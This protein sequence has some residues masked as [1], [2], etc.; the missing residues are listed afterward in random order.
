[1]SS[2]ALGVGQLPS[3][4]GQRIPPRRPDDDAPWEERLRWLADTLPPRPRHSLRVDYFVKASMDCMADG[5]PR[6]P[7][8]YYSVLRKLSRP[9]RHQGAETFAKRVVWPSLA[10]SL[11]AGDADAV[12]VLF[13][14]AVTSGSG[15][16][17]QVANRLTEAGCILEPKVL[18]SAVL[19]SVRTRD[20]DAFIAL[21]PLAL[22]SGLLSKQRVLIGT[23]LR[24]AMGFPENGTALAE[25]KRMMS[26]D[27][28]ACFLADS[29]AGA[30]AGLIWS[31][32]S[33]STRLYA[34]A[35]FSLLLNKP[36]SEIRGLA[37]HGLIWFDDPLGNPPIPVTIQPMAEEVLAGLQ[38]QMAVQWMKT[39]SL[40]Q[41]TDIESLGQSRWQ[42]NALMPN[43]L[44]EYLDLTICDAPGECAPTVV[45]D[46]WLDLAA[47]APIQKRSEMFAESSEFLGPP[48]HEALRRRYGM[49]WPVS[50][51][52]EALTEI[53]Y[54]YL[55]C[56]CA[57]K[58]LELWPL[59]RLPK[60]LRGLAL[61]R[62]R[63][64][65]E[66]REQLS[67][68]VDDGVLSHKDAF[69]MHLHRLSDAFDSEQE[70][71]TRPS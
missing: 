60:A 10:F 44:A 36:L 14:A 13:T 7:P 30:V 62:R 68:V 5:Q 49:L 21:E 12:R 33:A 71:G 40:R 46:C 67:A 28:S 35:I 17:P 22:R 26:A 24:R 38:G 15:V 4:R 16:P 1:M 61:S 6:L 56:A 43:V 41:I 69:R 55:V 34:N 52:Q 29:L 64:A 9:L 59:R 58:D 47:Q 18:Y 65:L 54:L 45:G 70:V 8:E 11:D 57:L 50:L 20:R 27:S 51:E 37:T 39:V 53:E 2:D 42:P 25:L 66:A 23:L 32:T 19:N 63:S 3:K 48:L 31:K